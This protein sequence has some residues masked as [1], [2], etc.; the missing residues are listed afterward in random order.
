MDFSMILIQCYNLVSKQIFVWI[1]ECFFGSTKVVSIFFHFLQTH[2]FE[3]TQNCMTTE[4]QK[5]TTKL[6]KKEKRKKKKKNRKFDLSFLSVLSPRHPPPHVCYFFPK[7]FYPTRHWS[8]IKYVCRNTVGSL[9][10][11]AVDF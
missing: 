8:L 1:S 5:E 10:K 6:E 9:W 4:T 11:L 2:S 3:S 7:I